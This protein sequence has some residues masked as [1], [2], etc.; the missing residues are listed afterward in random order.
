VVGFTIDL[1]AT[2]IKV[3]VIR[4][5]DWAL[6]QGD[7]LRMVPPPRGGQ[8]INVAV[9]AGGNGHQFSLNTEEFT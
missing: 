9:T 8:I 4:V 5:T 2:R 7:L 1:T 3:K 6:H